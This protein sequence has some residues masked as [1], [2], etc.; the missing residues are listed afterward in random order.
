[1]NEDLTTL[2]KLVIP[3]PPPAV[4]EDEEPSAK[5][6]NI[7]EV[8]ALSDYYRAS[9]Y[10][11]KI[12]SSYG[13]E[14][15]T[16]GLDYGVEVKHNPKGKKYADRSA[17]TLHHY[18]QGAVP[19]IKVEGKARRNSFGQAV[20]TIAAD[21]DELIMDLINTS[22]A[23]QQALP[24]ESV[25]VVKT[26]FFPTMVEKEDGTKRQAIDIYLNE[27]STVPLS[28]FYPL[29]G[30]LAMDMFVFPSSIS[31]DKT[32]G[33]LK[34]KVGVCTFFCSTVSMHT[35]DEGV[36]VQTMITTSKIKEL[37]KVFRDKWRKP[38]DESKDN[39]SPLF[40]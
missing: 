22:P 21:F 37:T 39:D 31:F 36:D 34:I 16:D 17:D 32:T 18:T 27:S 6:K 25:K 40:R 30:K 3:P 29:N 15:I 35:Y 13:L 33:V 9:P 28:T 26:N 20:I 2:S 12:A 1:M 23:I 38:E 7:E 5:K 14:L 10:Y 19:A 4:S 24:S 11:G 8:P